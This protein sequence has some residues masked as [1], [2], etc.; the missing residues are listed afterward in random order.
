MRLRG[1]LLR[2]GRARPLSFFASISIFWNLLNACKHWLDEIT[3]SISDLLFLSFW[4]SD[5]FLFCTTF[6]ISEDVC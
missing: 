5:A 3:N 4:S 2:R 6:R 1:I